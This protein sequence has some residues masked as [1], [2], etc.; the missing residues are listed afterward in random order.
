VCSSDLCAQQP[1]GAARDRIYHSSAGQQKENHTASIQLIVTS[2]YKT[3]T[4]PEQ[5]C[6][7]GGVYYMYESRTERKYPRKEAN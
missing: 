1:G 4:S 3:V 6:N 5:T 7:S 2:R